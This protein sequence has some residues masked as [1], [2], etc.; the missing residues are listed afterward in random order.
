MQ[1]LVMA[2]AEELPALE[3]YED[4]RWWVV[5]HLPTARFPLVCRGNTGEVYPNVV[6]PLTG[7]I[8]NV[9]FLRGQAKLSLEFGLMTADQAT[10]FDGVDGGVTGVFG[11]YL[12][13]NVSLARSVT[14]RTPGMTVEMID[15]QLYGLTG[16]PPHRRGSGERSVSASIRATRSLASGLLRPN[17]NQLQLDQ[18]DIAAYVAAIP[19]IVTAT[20][21]ELLAVPLTVAPFLERMMHNLLRASALAGFGRSLLERVVARVGDD[22]LVNQL[23]SG[24]GTIESAEPALALWDLGRL[25]ESDEDLTSLFDQGVSGL[26]ELLRSSSGTPSVDAFVDAF[27]DF[28][29]QHGSRGPDEWELASPTWGSDPSIALAVVDR[30][31][32]APDDRDPHRTRRRLASERH[33]LVSETR[34][35][36]PM[37]LRRAFD[38]TTRATMLYGAQREATKAAFVR[39]LHPSR[40]ALAELARRSTFSHDDFFLLTIDEVPGAMADPASFGSVIAERRHRRDYL[41]ARIPPFWFE[42]EVP[43]P[44]TWELRADRRQPEFEQRVIEGI[45]VCAGSA[46]GTARVVTDPTEPGDLRPGD[47]LIAPITDPAWTPLFLAV[48]GVVVDVGAQQSHAAI[49]ARELGIPAVV[50]ATGAS[51]TIPDGALVTV[52]GSTGRVTV[53]AASTS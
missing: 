10:Y 20:D 49:V 48:A 27:D 25:V 29:R 51:S 46:T 23:T 47:I 2:D 21:D 53:H 16:A 22:G 24:I 32:H 17:A 30:L 42:G 3:P 19:P 28:R 31:R 12:Y 13:G 45:G 26:D 1:Q 43:N 44:S 9:P 40:Q 5:D 6:T 50:S 38:I 52:D 8:V 4:G 34:R 35:A 36:L 15:R 18:R 41:Q 39:V 37:H 11:G 33:A 7:S 14:A